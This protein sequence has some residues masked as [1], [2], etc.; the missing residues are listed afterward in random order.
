MPPGVL[1][2]IPNQLFDISVFRRCPNHTCGHAAGKT[3][4][5]SLSLYSPFT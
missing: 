5:T 1:G 4:T 2:G 3:T